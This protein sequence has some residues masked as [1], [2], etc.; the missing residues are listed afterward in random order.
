M[1]LS[2][3]NF[4]NQGIMPSNITTYTNP[5]RPA[6]GNGSLEGE[7]ALGI[8]GYQ[9]GNPNIVMFQVQ[10]SAGTTSTLTINTDNS[11]INIVDAISANGT[12]I[13]DYYSVDVGVNTVSGGDWSLAFS[14]SLRDGK[15]APFKFV[16]GKTT[17][18]LPY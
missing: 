14:V 15:T 4:I 9:T 10:D 12:P 5:P 8:L 6:P 11:G 7:I 1:G 3:L 17:D 16:K 2:S 18:D 13:T